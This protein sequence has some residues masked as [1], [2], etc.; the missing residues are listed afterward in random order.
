MCISLFRYENII[1]DYSIEKFVSVIK[2]HATVKI[3]MNLYSKNSQSSR[4]SLVNNSDH[5]IFKQYKLGRYRLLM[6]VSRG[7]ITFELRLTE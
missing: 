1:K 7:A 4:K 3:F 2:T 5:G 6:S